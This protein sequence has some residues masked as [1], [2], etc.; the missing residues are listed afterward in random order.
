MQSF[1]SN[2]LPFVLSL[3]LCFCTGQKGYAQAALREICKQLLDEDQQPIQNSEISTR[4]DYKDYHLGTTDENGDI[5]FQ[6]PPSL[7]QRNYLTI[8]IQSLQV[9]TELPIMPS[10]PTTYLIRLPKEVNNLVQNEDLNSNPPLGLNNSPNPNESTSNVNPNN[11]TIFTSPGPRETIAPNALN[12]PSPLPPT[13]RPNIVPPNLNEDLASPSNEEPLKDPKPEENPIQDFSEALVTLE[14]INIK[15]ELGEKQTV[16]SS[17]QNLR[18]I[19]QK[20]KDNNL[21]SIGERNEILSNL[22]TQIQNLEVIQAKSEQNQEKLKQVVAFLE[23]KV[24]NLEGAIIINAY[25]QPFLWVLAGL[26][27]LLITFLILILFAYLRDRKM[28]RKLALQKEALEAQNQELS[29]KN[30]NIEKQQNQIIILIDE[31]H[32]RVK[33]NLQRIIYLLKLQFRS[34]DQE[35]YIA[36]NTIIDIQNRVY[37]M[38]LIHKALYE[39][40]HLDRVAC[41]EYIRQLVRFI[42]DAFDPTNQRIKLHT[43]IDEHI[44]LDITTAT[45]LGLIINELVSNAYKYAFEGQN[46]GEIWVKFQE[47]QPKHYLL[48]I[49]DNG[50]GLPEFILKNEYK[51]LGLTLVDILSRQLRAD[52]ERTNAQGTKYLIRF[53]K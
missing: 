26:I 25:W 18:E 45:N 42:A 19:A 44:N 23:R 49:A 20:L 31:I 6:L 47:P 34:I 15:D 9:K 43:H 12:T 17:I 27:F 38:S 35:N 16:Q 41:N 28:K 3:M 1:W 51:S 8:R 11:E 24:E 33:N 22:S 46:Q 5:C 37:S 29:L 52:V 48:E 39:Q 2:I 32:H 30:Q 4:I 13:E 10:S 21:N 36:R 14:K 53:D 50:I 7:N 40:D